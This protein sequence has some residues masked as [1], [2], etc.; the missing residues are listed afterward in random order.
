ML[1]NKR[2]NT[3]LKHLNYSKSFIEYSNDMDIIY[4]K[5]EEYNLNKKRKIFIVFAD[6]TADMLS[7]KRLNPIVTELFITGRKLNIFLV[8]IT[9]FYFFAKK[10]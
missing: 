10:Y 8:F 3:G 5:F 6:M 1:I 2:E 7:N 4:K 9:Q